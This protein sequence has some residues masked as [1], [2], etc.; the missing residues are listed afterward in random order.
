[1]SSQA[2]DGNDLI[3]GG[4]G[5]DTIAVA[6]GTAF[7]FS[8]NNAQL[9]NVEV[10]ALGSGSSVTLTGQGG[11]AEA[12]TINGGG[13]AETI[14]AGAGDDTINGRLGDDVITG[15]EGADSID[16]GAGVDTTSYADINI[17]TLL[18]VTEN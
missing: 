18:I 8:T 13:G 11:A 2:A 17:A 6:A 9:Q 7:T 5:V 3:D 14:V 12:F 15:A 10:V 1:M 16:G 4:T